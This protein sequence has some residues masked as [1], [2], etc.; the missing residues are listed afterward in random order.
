MV[1][2]KNH[3]EMWCIKINHAITWSIPSMMSVVKCLLHKTFVIK[4]LKGLNC[5]NTAK[6][7]MQL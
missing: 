4:G 7:C 5:L 2:N 3:T 6:C 1:N